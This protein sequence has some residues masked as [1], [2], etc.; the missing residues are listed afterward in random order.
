MMFPIP[1]REYALLRIELGAAGAPRL[2]LVCRGNLESCSNRAV[3]GQIV[4]R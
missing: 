4:L 1:A 2:Y 3:H